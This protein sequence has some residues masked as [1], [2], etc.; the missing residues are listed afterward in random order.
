LAALHRTRRPEFSSVPPINRSLVCTEVISKV[1]SSAN[2]ATENAIPALL[3]PISEE[4]QK[5]TNSFTTPLEDILISMFKMLLEQAVHRNKTMATSGLQ[6]N[7][8]FAHLGDLY[9]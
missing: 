9:D 4:Y 1:L 2:N 8:S 6:G 7:N 3:S 5:I